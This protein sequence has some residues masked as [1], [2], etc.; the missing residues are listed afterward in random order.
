[1][2]T[3]KRQQIIL[4]KLEAQRTVSLQELLQEMKVSESTIR[5]DLSQLEEAGKLVRIHGGARRTYSLDTEATFSDK[6]SQNQS[7]KEKIAQIAA[8][9]IQPREVIYLDAGTTTL[10]MLPHLVDKQLTVVTNGI[11]QAERLNALGIET[12]LIGGKVKSRTS[13]VIG[14]TAYNQLKQYRFDRVFMGMNGVD[15]EYGYT[16]PD[17]EEATIKQLA[18]AQGNHVYVLTDTSKIGKVS[19]C[20]VA[21]IEDATLITNVLDERLRQQLEKMTTVKEC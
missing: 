8:E 20:H 7:E 13:A 19:F 16:T 1:M 5:R 18:M 4:Q 11:Q 12:I 3:E 17:I 9:Y 21:N 2:L 15:A 10:C 14:L 6:I